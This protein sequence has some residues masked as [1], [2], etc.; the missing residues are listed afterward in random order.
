MADTT[1][2]F[3]FPSIKTSAVKCMVT[4]GD[5]TLGGEHTMQ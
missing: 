1:G 3:W 4:E 2:V 5:S